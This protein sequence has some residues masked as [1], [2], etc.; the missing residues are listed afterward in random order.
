VQYIKQNEPQ[1]AYALHI[2]NT[3][4]EYGPINNIMSVL[5]KVN[6]DPLLNPF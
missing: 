2:L 1:S 3:T 6:Q 5:K 4:H